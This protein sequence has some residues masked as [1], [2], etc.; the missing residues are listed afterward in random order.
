MTTPLD[1]PV[2]DDAEDEVTTI[3]RHLVAE[4]TSA[5][6]P[7]LAIH[8]LAL[9]RKVAHMLAADDAGSARDVIG[10]LEAAPPVILPGRKPEPTL[11]QLARDDRPID[12]TLLT[13]EQIGWLEECVAV[14]TGRSCPMVNERREA[15]LALS[16]HLDVGEVDVS[17]IRQLIATVFRGSAVSVADVFPN[18][19]AELAELR[20]RC[21]GLEEQAKRLEHELASARRSLPSNVASLA[22]ERAKQAER[23]A[24]MHDSSRW[25]LWQT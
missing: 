11:E 3:F 19:E 9:L 21:A 20:K 16:D 25:M 8:Q 14:G 7:T 10:L 18:G 4:R 23:E 12:V 17:W 13:N 15:C 1:E 5:Q 2:M 22:E 24:A 6:T